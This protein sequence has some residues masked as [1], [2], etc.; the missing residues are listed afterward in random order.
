M[1]LSLA[2]VL[3]LLASP[4]GAEPAECD[5]LLGMVETAIGLEL[6]AP[7]AGTRDGWCVLDGARSLDQGS[8][9]VSVEKLRL[10]GEEIDDRL[11][12]LEIEGTGLRVAPALNNREVPDWLR[13]LLRLQSADLRLAVRRDDAGDVLLL[14]RAQLWLSSG[15]M[16]LLTGEVAG[17]EL[18]ASSLLT[19]RLTKLY[20]EWQNDGRTLRPILEA[21]GERLEPGATGTRAVLATR[22]ALDALVAAMPVGSLLDGLPYGLGDFIAAL[23]QGRGRLLLMAGSDTGI[24]AAQQGL[25]ALAEDPTGPEAL[26]KLFEG[27]RISVSWNPGI[28]P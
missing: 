1:R 3:A 11:L 12:A 19:G 6:T 9:R 25:L 21:W 14:E 16:L 26:A 24:G 22:E 4:A 20:L 2:L 13:D 7:P 23:P 28:A 8:V 17:A 15:G 5:Q 18:S 27:T 10:R